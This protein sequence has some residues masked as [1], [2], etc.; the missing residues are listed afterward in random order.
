MGVRGLAVSALESCNIFGKVDRIWWCLIAR[1][2]MQIP[3]NPSFAMLAR[4]LSQ[5][6]L[7]H[8]CYTTHLC[9]QA[10]YESCYADIVAL[11]E[12]ITVLGN[13]LFTANI[14]YTPPEL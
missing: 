7:K 3:I 1:W 11:N 2:I 8:Q 10:R 12:D 6:Y 13:V 14:S 9:H 4:L 5:P